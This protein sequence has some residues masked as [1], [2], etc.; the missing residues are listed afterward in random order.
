MIWDCDQRCIGR[1]QKR[2][3]EP[4]DTLRQIGALCS[5]LRGLPT[6][7]GTN[8]EK[9]QCDAKTTKN[10]SDCEMQSF[11]ST[12]LQAFERDWCI[13]SR[14]VGSTAAEQRDVMTRGQ[15]EAN[16]ALSAIFLIVLVEPP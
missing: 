9:S 14:L 13:C 12:L 8:K 16:H 7:P 5:G 4:L 2:T 1:N 11:W 6:L 10:Q 15:V 3:P